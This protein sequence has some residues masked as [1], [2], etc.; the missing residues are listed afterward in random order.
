MQNLK[1]PVIKNL[2]P[3]IMT[4]DYD[5]SWLD[6]LIE[7]VLYT[8]KNGIVN[9]GLNT[10][11]KWAMLAEKYYNIVHT[12]NLKYAT[13]YER[14]IRE[15][16]M[17]AMIYYSDK[18]PLF[19]SGYDTGYNVMHYFPNAEYDWHKDGEKGC[20]LILVMNLNDNFDKGHLLVKHFNLS[21]KPKSG[22]MI[23]MPPGH[24]FEHKGDKVLNGDK[25][26]LRS[27]IYEKSTNAVGNDKNLRKFQKKE[28]HVKGF[29]RNKK[30]IS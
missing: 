29:I 10:N 28:D 4:L 1:K 22:R 27:R 20:S 2:A 5:I 24:T 23:L 3:G 16:L 25:F 9:A 17:D 6:M 21:I 18:Y 14:S 12:R 13:F 15:L 11:K 8:E 19:Q 30:E 26:I 7:A